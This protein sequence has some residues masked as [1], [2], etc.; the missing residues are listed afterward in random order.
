MNYKLWILIIAWIEIIFVLILGYLGFGFMSVVSNSMKHEDE[1]LFIQF[2]QERGCD[3]DCLK[4]FPLSNGFQGGDL[5]IFKKTSNYEKGDIVPYRANSK[6]IIHR[7]VDLNESQA[8]FQ[9]DNIK[10]APGSAMPAGSDMPREVIERRFT[11]GKIIFKI[12]KLG[13]I[14]A[15]LNCWA[16]SCDIS[17][18]ISNG[19]C[20]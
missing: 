18:C 5:L 2:W 20:N 10:K 12:P 8:F 1:A 15:L 11:I 9:G 3:I 7:L 16:N 14:K 13:L 19:N 6:I 4:N 17:R